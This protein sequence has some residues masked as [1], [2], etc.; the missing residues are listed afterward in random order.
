MDRMI[1]LYLLM[2]AFHAGLV[3][4]EVFGQ[5]WVLRTMGFRTFLVVNWAI[6]CIPIGLF[7]Y[8]L[9]LRRWAITL[10]MIYA[11][12]MIALSLGLIVVFIGTRWYFGG[13]AGIFAGAGVVVVGIFLLLSLRRI[14]EI[15]LKDSPWRNGYWSKPNGKTNSNE[16]RGG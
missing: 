3:L 8:V 11:G 15:S 7:Y 4:E 10:S 12:A 9:K 5:S 6:L 2:I 13:A 14:R 16:F 1:K